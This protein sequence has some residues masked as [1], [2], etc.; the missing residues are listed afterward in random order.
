MEQFYLN[1]RSF[2]EERALAIPLRS[3]G[4]G[5]ISCHHYSRSRRVRSGGLLL[6]T[7]ALSNLISISRLILLEIDISLFLF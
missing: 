1:L 2:T 6:T 5:P 3:F 4:R 7:R